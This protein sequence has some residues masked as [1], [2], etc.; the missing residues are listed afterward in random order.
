LLPLPDCQ[1]APAADG[2]KV[3]LLIDRSFLLSEVPDA[4]RYLLQRHRHGKIVITM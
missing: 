1:D 4:I 2:S 3:T